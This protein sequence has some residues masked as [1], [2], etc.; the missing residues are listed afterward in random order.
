MR[1]ITHIPARQR[2]FDVI[3]LVAAVASAQ[4]R[5]QQ[6]VAPS[7]AV[8]SATQQGTVLDRV[9]AVV[10]GT[11]V[12]ESDVDEEQRFEQ[13]Q[14]YRGGADFTREQ[15]LQRIINRMLIQQEAVQQQEE[16]DVSDEELDKQLATLRTDIPAC[17]QFHCETEAG[18]KQFLA[19]NGFT[20]GEFRDRWRLRMQLLRFV[21]VRFQGGVHI[22]D[23]QIRDYY[24][25]TMLP[26]YQRQ[27]ATP[28]KLEAVS[29]RI[30]EVLL[31]Q[32]VTNLLRDWLA[33]LR[34][35]GSVRIIRQGEVDR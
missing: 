22:T 2:I 29:Q 11:P 18:W 30:E 9:V 20:E 16:M 1:W 35:Q 23:D 6:P 28:P 25:K 3:A 27:K 15:A 14:P 32:Q 31:Q 8:S 34:V 13:I 12:L 7:P 24:E 10:N 5:A 4:L 26:E 21:Q 19:Q 17:R 33:S